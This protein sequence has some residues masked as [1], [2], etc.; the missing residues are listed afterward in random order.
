MQVYVH[1]Q[2]VRREA[3]A[4]AAS[5][6]EHPQDGA[7]AAP[8]RTNHSTAGASRDL[9]R[10]ALQD[11]GVWAVPADRGSTADTEPHEHG[12]PSLSIHELLQDTVLDGQGSA[13]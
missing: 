5:P 8:T 12:L 4:P 7:L 11:T 3:E 6:E 13:A 10:H 9:E 2:R 1:V